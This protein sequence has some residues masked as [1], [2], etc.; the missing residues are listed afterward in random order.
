MPR[1]W[2]ERSCVFRSHLT[3]ST[4][5]NPQPPAPTLTPT[6]TP[7]P[8]SD[9]NPNPNANPN[10]NPTGTTFSAERS[11]FDRTKEALTTGAKNDSW[12]E[13]LK[14]L[15]MYSQNLLGRSQ[16]LQEVGRLGVRVRARVRVTAVG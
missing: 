9:P 1:C 16:M 12:S 14:A 11:F 13:F 2:F 8:N 3:P 10:A 4:Y 6:L 7:T 5:S 15:E